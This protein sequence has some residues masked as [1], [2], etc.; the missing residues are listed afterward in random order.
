MALWMRNRWFW[1]PPPL[2][3]FNS[4]SPDFSHSFTSH[5]RVCCI[6]KTMMAYNHTHQTKRDTSGNG[7][8]QKKNNCILGPKGNPKET[9]NQCYEVQRHLYLQVMASPDHWEHKPF[10][11]IQFGKHF[12]KRMYLTVDIDPLPFSSLC[13]HIQKAE[14]LEQSRLKEPK[15]CRETDKLVKIILFMNTIVLKEKYSKK[16]RLS[17]TSPWQERQSEDFRVKDS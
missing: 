15:W 8:L 16:I 6:T 7:T 3:H 11:M 4:T 2:D 9:W 14:G 17:T 5:L 13:W 12:S 10:S 1:L